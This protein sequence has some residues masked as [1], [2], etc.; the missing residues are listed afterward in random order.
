MSRRLKLSPSVLGELS[1]GPFHL[2]LHV[3]SFGNEIRVPW[4][5]QTAQVGTASELSPS[6]T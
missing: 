5:E 3:F 6:Q 1:T 4:A 2:Y